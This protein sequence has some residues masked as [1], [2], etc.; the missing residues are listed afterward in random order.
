MQIYSDKLFSNP[1]KIIEAFDDEEF[2]K[3]FELIEKY[4]KT[5]YLLGYIRYEAKDIFLNKNIK[6]KLPLLYFEVFENYEEY[7]PK[8]IKE[9][10]FLNAIPNIS[11]KKYEENIQKTRDYIAA[12][13]TYQVNYTYDCNLEYFG[14][15]IEL[16]E[17]ILAKQKTPYNAF[18]QNKYEKILSFSPELFFTLEN[19]IIKT[20]PMK[21]TV[22]RGS[23]DKEDLENIEFLKNDIKNRA[24]NIMIVDLLRNDLGKIVKTGSVKVP[25][26]FEIE[27]HP[28]VHQ[29]T[30]E[31]EGELEEKTT[32]Y[33][34]FDAIFPC[35]SITGAPKINTMKIIEELEGKNRHIYCGAIGFIS[36]EK[37][38]FSVPI[39]ILQKQKSSKYYKYYVGGAIVWDSTAEDEWQETL[40]KTKVVSSK[41]DFKLVETIKVEDKKLVLRDLH[42]KRM[43]ES[44]KKLGFKFNNDL[45]KIKPEK[46]G[47]LRILL[48]TNGDFELEYQPY[49]NSK[50]NKIILAKNPISSKEI[51]LRHKTTFKPWY[52][53]SYEKIKNSEIYDEIFFNEKNELT[54]GAR[55][56]I[57]LE[58]KG[59]MYTPKLKSG[60]LN[61][62][63]RQKM[64]KE[65][66]ILEKTLYI[67]DL[68][69]AD[70]IYCIN[71]VRGIKKVVLS[72]SD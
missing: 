28:T 64:L 58:I 62:V 49:N 23:T 31:V 40:T 57:V 26:L 41:K 55:T 20:K 8:T 63:L 59:K 2:K 48:S 43:K 12:G 6:S 71:S 11:Y 5:H 17:Y 52:E 18:I 69:K 30:S 34:I 67:D 24:E 21:G 70:E 56:N 1:I 35:G 45:L 13:E 68:I 60:L 47:I 65:G 42:F 29:M 16:Y 22:K 53:K 9:N 15:P 33:D 14:E 66:S 36:L 37:S 72:D 3:A 39:R 38:V 25:K 51:L 27:T 4:R 10:I 44:A 46:D 61:G 7:K 50:T 32:L 19:N 54:E